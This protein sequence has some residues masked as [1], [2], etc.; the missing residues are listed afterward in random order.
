M[1][2]A[3]PFIVK[4]RVSS[5]PGAYSLVGFNVTNSSAGLLVSI[6]SLDKWGL[7]FTL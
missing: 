5:S 2:A 4:M 7:S 6:Y 3:M 1:P